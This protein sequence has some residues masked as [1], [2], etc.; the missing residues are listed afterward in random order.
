M[1]NTS[2]SILTEKDDNFRIITIGASAGGFE[3]LKELVKG[4][5]KDFPAAILVVW[6]VSPDVTGILPEVLSRHGNLRAANAVD[7]EPIEPGRIYVAPP[8]HH[9]LVE[10]GR[11]RVT[12]G[13]KE[14]RFRPA[15]DPLFRSAA[16]V[17][18][19]RVIGVVLSGALDDGT[20]GLWMIKHCCGVAIV[21][22]PNDAEVPSMPSNALRE[23]AVDYCVPVSEMAGLLV[24]L[25]NE[26]IEFAGEVMEKDKLT[27]IEI[28]IAADDKSFE[29]GIM[30]FGQLSPFACPE[31]HGVLTALKEGER[32]RFRCH[33]G[34]AFSA[35]SLLANIT[36]NIEETLWSAIR[37]IDESV[38]LLNQMGD[39][40]ANQNQINLSALYFKKAYE[41]KQRSDLV[42]QAAMKNERMSK[43]SLREQAGAEKS[44]IT[45][46]N[47]DDRQ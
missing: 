26:Q 1:K 36:E 11:V 7:G 29:A 41:A 40:Y 10:S 4:L 38:M 27:E 28:K 20:S 37:G 44:K 32:A 3:A 34:H 6:H 46:E 9:L 19:R 16:Y 39:Y 5:P 22:E 14:N 8:D 42:R 31:C 15:V 45:I 25:T 12:K 35:D 24:R 18:S 43:D 23:V 13:P 21:Q 17:Y 2:A 47:G 30:N 33:T